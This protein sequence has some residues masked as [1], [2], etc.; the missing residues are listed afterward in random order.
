[1]N[2]FGKAL[3]EKRRQAGV[4]Q[5]KLANSVGVD[6]SYISKLE[7]GRLPAP[8]AETIARIAKAIGC[9]IE[10]LFSAAKKIPNRL[11]N[12]IASEPAALRF[13]NEASKLRLS[14]KDW[15]KMIGSLHNLRTDN[16][17]RKR[18]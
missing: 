14:T 7:N 5:R 3:R 4:S 11:G 12:S 17:A 16:Q 15:E 10:E 6:F 2:E 8:S 1:M 13:L 9:P 18:K